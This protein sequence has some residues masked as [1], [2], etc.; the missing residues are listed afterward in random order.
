M[1]WVEVKS[2]KSTLQYLREF[3]SKLDSIFP[4]GELYSSTTDWKNGLH[5]IKVYISNYKS[6]S[7]RDEWDKIYIKQI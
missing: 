4:E 3:V 2:E 1:E 5:V 6:A 7:V